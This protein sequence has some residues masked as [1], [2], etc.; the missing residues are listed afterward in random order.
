MIPEENHRPD[1]DIEY[2][3]PA[4]AVVNLTRYQNAKEKNLYG[5]DIKHLNTIAMKISTAGTTRH[6]SKTWHRPKNQIIEVEM[7]ESQFGQMISSFN[8]GCGTPVTLRWRE[9]DGQIPNIETDSIHQVFNREMKTSIRKN[10]ENVQKVGKGL[11]AAIDEGKLGKKTLE[12]LI[13]DL[14]ILLNNLPGNLAYV[15]SMFHES[16]EKATTAAKLEIEAFAQARQMANKQLPEPAPLKE[17]E[18]C[19]SDCDCNK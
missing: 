12:P 8:Q 19:G 15:D 10:I 5:S 18:W 11:R 9:G 7:S 4:F 14:E 17:C 16:M 13:R 6:G 2:F 1:G 3:H